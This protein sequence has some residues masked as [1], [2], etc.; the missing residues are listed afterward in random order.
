MGSCPSRKNMKKS[1]KSFT[2]L[3]GLV[4][5]VLGIITLLLPLATAYTGKVSTPLGEATA[6]VSSAY[7]FIF[8]ATAK[9]TGKFGGV[10]TTTDG[11]LYRPASLALVGWILIV[12][13]LVA[14]VAAIYTVYA[15][16]RFGKFAFFGAALLFIVGGVLLFCVKEQLCLASVSDPSSL[17]KDAIEAATSKMTL[18]FGFIGTGIAGILSGIASGVAGVFAK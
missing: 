7:C 2:L 15:K 18:G 5:A 3:L 4:A 8:G 12:L 13:A 1:K 14:V 10:Q 11:K 9:A 17:S 6:V 16:K